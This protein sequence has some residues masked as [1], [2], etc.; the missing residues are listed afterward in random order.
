MIDT[1]KRP[2]QTLFNTLTLF[3]IIAP[4]SPHDGLFSANIYL[5]LPRSISNKETNGDLHIWPLSI[6]SRWDWYKNALLLSGLTTQDAVSQMK[7]RKEL[8]EPLKICVEPGDLVIMCVQRPH[9]AMGFKHGTRVSL[10]CFVQ[11]EGIDKR[12]LIDS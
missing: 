10:Q 9:A 8:G 4:L 6:R 3:I 12:L 11:H 5:Q 7:L 1:V 2:L